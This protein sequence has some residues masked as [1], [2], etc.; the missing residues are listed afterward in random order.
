MM[1]FQYDTMTGR[2]LRVRRR[3]YYSRKENKVQN[4]IKL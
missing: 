4:I 1:Y 2:R 3:N